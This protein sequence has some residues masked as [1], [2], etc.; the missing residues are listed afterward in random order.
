MIFAITILLI[1]LI[2]CYLH[3]RKINF[4][5]ISLI[6]TLIFC[7]CFYLTFKPKIEYQNVTEYWYS[8]YGNGSRLKETRTYQSPI[9]IYNANEILLFSR[10]L[11]LPVFIIS[12]I[13]FSRLLNK[14][15][16][17]NQNIEEH[18]E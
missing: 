1:I 8:P 4:F 7:N 2:F 17:T 12:I 3:N 5:F 9:T 10:F 18:N 13:T 14:K 15:P 6:S 16:K 11:F